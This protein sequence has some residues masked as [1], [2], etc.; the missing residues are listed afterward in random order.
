MP[1]KSVPFARVADF[2]RDIFSSHLLLWVCFVLVHIWLA[3]LNLLGPGIP[4]GDVVYTYRFWMD[5]AMIQNYWVGID[6]EWV[7]PIVAIVPMMIAFVFGPTFYGVAWIALVTV[8][9]ACAFGLLTGWG[10]G[11]DRIA[12]AWWWLNFLLFIGPIALG[13]VDSVSV[14]IAIIAV[15]MLSRRPRFAAL[16]LVVATWIKVWPA[17]LLAAIV[18]ASKHRVTT[19]WIA[20][21]A[22]AAIIATALALGSGTHVFSFITQ[23]AGRGLQVE[24]PVSTLWLWQAFAGVPGAYVYY[25]QGI[26]TYQIAG[27]GTNVAAALMTPLMAVVAL[28]VVALGVV[29]MRRGAA[30]VDVFAPLALGLVVTLIAFN[31][32]GSPQFVSWLAVPV[33]LGLWMAHAGSSV[34]FRVPAILVLA[35]AALTQV[36]YPALYVYL[37]SLNSLMLLVISVRNA[38]YFVLLAWAVSE[39]WMLGA[40]A[41]SRL[42]GDDELPHNA[43]ADWPFGLA[44]RDPL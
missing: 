8:L 41:R 44:Q 35:I 20:L 39:L 31:K 40:R 28:A 22:S 15:L 4:L 33:I 10:H 18:V 2:G 34:S 37:L 1:P 3:L 29:A 16:L 32:V 26:L 13:R 38:L 24:A 27:T 21:G 12:V 23:Q 7:Y 6:G 17:A 19:V 9:N 11:R 14:P 25:D 43:A 36:L 5:Q 30:S 42:P